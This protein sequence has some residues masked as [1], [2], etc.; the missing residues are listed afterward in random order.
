MMSDGGTFDGSSLNLHEWPIR[1]LVNRLKY[2][3]VWIISV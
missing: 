3:A 1:L 2:S